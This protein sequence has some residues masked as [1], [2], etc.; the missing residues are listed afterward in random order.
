MANAQTTV[1]PAPVQQTTT[2]QTPAT[3]QG[4]DKKVQ[5]DAL[6]GASYEDGAA[7]LSPNNAA[8]LKQERA[9]Q[10]TAPAQNEKKP[11]VKPDANG[12]VKGKTPTTQTTKP[13]TYDVT[14]V[15]PEKGGKVVGTGAGWGNRKDDTLQP[16]D[17]KDPSKGEKIKNSEVKLETVTGIPTPKTDKLP[18]TYKKE[19]QGSYGTYTSTEVKSGQVKG[20]SGEITPQTYKV[21]EGGNVKGP[22]AY[23]QGGATAKTA[24]GIKGEAENDYG[25]VEGKTEAY[26]EAYGAYSGEAGVSNKGAKAEFIAGTG[27]QVGVT[28]DADAKT[29][30]LK[31]DGVEKDLDMGVGVHGE[32]QAYVKAG[33]QG[34]VYAT[35]DKMGVEFKGGAAIAAEAKAD[36]HGNVGP[37]SGKLEAGVLAGAGIGGEFAIVYEDGKLRIGARAYAALGY[38]VSMGG[39]VEIDLKQSYQLAVAVLK[40]AKEVGIKGAEIAFKAADADNDGKLTLNDGATHASNAMQGA[41]N[42]LDKGADATISALD[43][44]GDGKFSMQ[45]DGSAAMNQAG[46]Y[47]ADKAGQAKDY[48]VDKAGQAK[49]YVVEKG[50]QVV[51]GTKN[52]LDMNGDKQ[53]GVDDVVAGYEKGKAWTEEKLNQAGETISQTADEVVDWGSNQIDNAIEAAQ[54]THKVLDRT[55]DGKLGMDDVQKGA[56]EVYNASSKAVG[57]AVDWTKEK[58][59]Q[60][61]AWAK[62]KGGQA[63]DWAKEKGGQA[64]DWAKEK[65]KQTVKAVHNAADRDGNGKLDM[66]DVKAG[67]EQAGQA[68]DN[69]L[70]Q[71][72]QT[73]QNGYE[74][75]KNKVHQVGQAVY[76]AADLNKDGKIDSKDAAVA[77]KRAQ[78]A[79]AWAKQKALQT[80]A[81][82]KKK[83]EA[84][85]AQMK[86]K[87]QKVKAAVKSAMDRNGDGKVDAADVKA[88]AKQAYQKAVQIKNSV[89]STA[90]SAYQS[91]TAALNKAGQTLSNGYQKASATVANTYNKLKNFFW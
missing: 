24:A 87:A 48:V 61:A 36:I 26:A 25:K 18:S 80:A 32:A 75:A 31:V 49:D 17:E 54:Q 57:Q 68:I 79:A 4:S 7:L 15:Q 74:A 70:Q 81:A 23:I 53:L 12:E 10:K 5:K 76:K 16:V 30:G 73:L 3:T 39:E 59:G 14:P 51:E 29:K 77:A 8:P 83:A 34:G 40:K 44:D 47:I 52:A 6:R 37:V 38:G 82:A 35:K 72:K 56:G 65:G 63:V 19:T 86:A 85:Y 50:K 84:V 45:K 69:S 13:G 9:V 89:V 90:K 58:G 11:V 20:A 1:K 62:E 71:A 22:N 28:A 33:V 41:A 64:V 2:S 42:T 88:G 78:Q 66:G 46:E 67:V 60:A 55:G 91:T 27:A 43:R 21:G